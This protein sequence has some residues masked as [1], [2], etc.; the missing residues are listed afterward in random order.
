M[1][2]PQD[3]GCRA[4]ARRYYHHSTGDGSRC[5]VAP[6]HRSITRASGVNAG[7]TALGTIL[8]CSFALRV[9]TNGTTDFTYFAHPAPIPKYALDQTW[10]VVVD[11]DGFPMQTVSRTPYR[12][13]R[14]LCGS[15]VLQAL[16]QP[17]RYHDF[18]ACRER[19]R[20]RIFSGTIFRGDSSR[21]KRFA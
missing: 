17:T 14:R 20:E 6:I 12:D 4:P 7:P 5:R 18:Y 2:A 16:K 19:N 8:A 10:N 21:T 13:F 9:A 11:V 15:C 3:R 1:P